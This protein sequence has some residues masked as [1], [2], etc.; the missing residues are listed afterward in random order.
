MTK[1]VLFVAEAATLAH[2]ARPLV[3]SAALD[4]DQFE[5]SFACDPRCQWLLHDLAGRYFPL[6]SMPSEHFLAALA[7]GTPLYDEAILNGYVRDDLTLLEQVRPDAVVGDFRLSLS[8]SARLAGIPYLAISNCYWSPYWRPPRYTVPNLLLTRLLPLP[9]ADALFQLARPIAFALH[10]RPLNRV[11]RNHG[12]PSLGSDLRRVYTDADQVLYADVPELFPGVDLPAHHH[13]LGPVLWSPPVAAPDWWDTIPNNRPIVY[14][15]LGSSGQAGL[16]P[17]ILRSLAELDITVIAATAGGKLPEV[18]PVNA[19][20]AHYLP[21]EAAAR[22]ARL[23]IC[24]G[25]SPTSQQALAAGVPVIGV[26]S[27]LDQFLNMGMVARAG[28]GE[29]MRADRFK[30][31][32]LGKLVTKLLGGTGHAAAAR[33]IAAIISGHDSRARF[34]AVVRSVLEKPRPSPGEALA[35]EHLLS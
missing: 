2:V 4:R 31:P 13:F 21:G 35:H 16:L 11:R 27:N 5:I 20:V 10:C 24:N 3:L 12:L 17:E 34:V 25:G 14:V 32:A 1:R 26:A 8:I 22:R 30:G 33:K 19:Y 23:V 18:I 9:L 29:I 28:A 7:H 6:S 15:T